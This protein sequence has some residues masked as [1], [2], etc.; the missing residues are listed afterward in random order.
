[1]KAL[2]LTPVVR[3]LGPQGIEA[4]HR[5]LATFLK[6]LCF[7]LLLSLTLLLGCGGGSGRTASRASG[8]SSGG[9]ISSGNGGN[10][11]STALLV[12]L[13]EFSELSDQIVS[14]E[15]TIDSVALRS[16]GGEVSQLLPNARRVELSRFKAEPL[17][18]ANVHQG[19]YSG[20][21]VGISNPTIS[22]IDSSGVLHEDVAASLTSTMVTNSSEFSFD[23]TPR[24][25][26]INLF[27]S[28]DFG[29]SVTVAPA[30]NFSTGGGPS[31]DL[32][33]RVTG[34]RS[35]SFAVDTG[36]GTF[37]F[38]TD[39][40]TEFQGVTGLNELTVGS[41]VELD[42]FLGSDGIFR[43]TKVKLENYLSSAQVVEGLTLSTSLAHLQMLV[44]EVHGPSEGSLPAV[45]KALTV[46]TNSSTQFRLEPDEVDL[47]NLNFTPSFDALSIALGQNVRAAFA[48]SGTTI[49]ADQ[50]K[51]EEQSLDGTAGSVTPGS[52]PGQF[53]FPLNLSADSAFA[54]LTGHTSIL[55]TLQPSAQKFL[56]LGFENCVTCIAGG[57]VRVRGLLFLSGGQY[58]L[59][60]EWL[61]VI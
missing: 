39:S 27:L 6:G 58:R 22:F 35:S 15:L 37:S 48:G 61:A 25:I 42:A 38:T 17:L 2:V 43:A 13:G 4:N 11:S 51:L 5:S 60:A 14:F 19:K 30:L 41:T 32:V 47:K 56:Y 33:G 12:S 46:A 54:R 20:V 28:A 40:S 29:E 26:S 34:V 3:I 45:G 44:R 1:M 52:V 21:A 53:T 7:F 10:T 16:S 57:E 8:G 36:N 49:I 31:K 59:V 9:G 23:S 50:L 55:I 24:S 18:L